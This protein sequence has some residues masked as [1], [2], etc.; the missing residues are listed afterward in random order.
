MN[1]IYGNLWFLKWVIVNI[2]SS[3][4]FI[5][6][7]IFK[8]ILWIFFTQEVCICINPFFVFEATIYYINCVFIHFL[9]GRTG[10]KRRKKERGCLR[11]G[12]MVK[13]KDEE[14]Q[15]YVN[16]VEPVHR[17]TQILQ[18]Y[19]WLQKSSNACMSTHTHRLYSSHAHIYT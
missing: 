10:K 19:C 8:W 16:S 14:K 2:G 4:L 15:V 3:Y 17:H 18:T 6:S 12:I 11:W 9:L 1:F 7:F 5:Y 13:K